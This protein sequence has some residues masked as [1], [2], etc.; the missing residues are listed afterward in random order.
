MMNDSK[1]AKTLSERRIDLRRRSARPGREDRSG[2]LLLPGEA[3]AV[4]LGGRCP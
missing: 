4:S 2:A 3:V 1:I